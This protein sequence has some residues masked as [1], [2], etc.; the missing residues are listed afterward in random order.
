MTEPERTG[1]KVRLMPVDFEEGEEM[2]AAGLSAPKVYHFITGSAAY[3]LVE[4]AEL[5]RWRASRQADPN[6]GAR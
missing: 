3:Y 1:G 4:P 6:G 2:L 5:E